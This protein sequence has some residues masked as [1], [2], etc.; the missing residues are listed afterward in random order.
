MMVEVISDVIKVVVFASNTNTLLTV[1]DA[2]IRRHVTVWVDSTQ[3]HRLELQ[4]EH[5]VPQAHIV[6]MVTGDVVC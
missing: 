6:A 2:S 4:V 3:K 5:T 1:D